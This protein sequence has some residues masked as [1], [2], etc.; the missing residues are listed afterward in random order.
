MAND[1]SKSFTLSI[2]LNCRAHEAL[3]TTREVMRI[4]FG[5]CDIN[6]LAIENVSLRDGSYN[7]LFTAYTNETAIDRVLN[8]VVVKPEPEAEAPQAEPEDY[9]EDEVD[10]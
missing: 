10:A 2:D 6:L 7:T 1:R 5:T 9:K 3:D 8:P 4:L